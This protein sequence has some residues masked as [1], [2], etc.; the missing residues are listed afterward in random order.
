MRPRHIP[1]RTCVA[2]QSRKP[3]PELVRL[4]KQKEGGILISPPG[5]VPGRGVY[6]CREEK[7]WV[8]GIEKGRI[9]RA[10]RSSVASE[11]AASIIAW[12]KI[13]LGDAE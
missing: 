13:Y 8:D 7:C 10:I 4:V 3:Q 5:N 1:V 2:C 12:A 11:D 6:L 9:A